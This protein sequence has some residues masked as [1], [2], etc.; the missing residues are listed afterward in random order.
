MRPRWPTGTSASDGSRNTD[1]PESNPI[2]ASQINLFAFYIIILYAPG[3]ELSTRRMNR[4]SCA[5]LDQGGVTYARVPE[6][7]R[8][9][10][11]Y[12]RAPGRR[13]GWAKIIRGG[14]TGS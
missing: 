2:Y 5:T 4:L 8:T 10:N 3:T 12:A 1:I 6:V 7:R 14:Q 11:E 9:G 13:D